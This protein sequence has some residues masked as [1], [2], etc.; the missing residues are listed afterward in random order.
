MKAP[1]GDSDKDPQGLENSR[2]DRIVG[3][4][5]TSA[6]GHGLLHGARPWRRGSPSWCRRLRQAVDGD[7]E[8]S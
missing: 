5:N 2:G 1:P 7:F 3:R 4:A 6:S 8:T